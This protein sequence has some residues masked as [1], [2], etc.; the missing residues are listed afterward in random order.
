MGFARHVFSAVLTVAL[1][2]YAF[3]CAP[4]A[5]AEQAMQCCKSMQCMRHGHH[6]QDCCKTMPS[7]RDVV[8]QPTSASHSLSQAAFGVVQTF[9]E[10]VSIAT[11][12]RLITDQ[13]HAP[14]IL[15]LPSVL[16][17]RI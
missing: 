5:T 8:G 6:G 15:S 1:A 4:G 12:A 2:G 7:T 3:D 16:L 17:L 10:S 14:P 9:D 11:S 13:S